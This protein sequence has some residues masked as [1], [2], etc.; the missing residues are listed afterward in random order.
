[1]IKPAA[2]LQTIKADIARRFAEENL[3]VSD[4]A[5]SHGVTPRYVHL[6]FEPEGQT[7]SEFLI[8]Q[9][10]TQ[11]H[12]M[13]T[14]SQFAGRSISFIAYEVGFANLSY[15]NRLFRRRYG[16]TPSRIRAAAYSGRKL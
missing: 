3:S 6:L 15:F 16:A 14:D 9:R 5:R 1:M 8:E 12:R 2:R 4:V 10:L 13:L 11:A 7:F